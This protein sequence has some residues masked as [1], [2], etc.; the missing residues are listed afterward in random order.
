MVNNFRDKGFILLFGILLVQDAIFL[1]AEADA[2]E[3][4]GRRATLRTIFKIFRS[5]S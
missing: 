3:K 2:A 4:V 5:V 1:V